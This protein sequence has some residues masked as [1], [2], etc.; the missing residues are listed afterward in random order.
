MIDDFILVEKV[1]DSFCEGDET[2]GRQKVEE[3]RAQY[4]TVSRFA[5][6]CRQSSCEQFEGPILGSAS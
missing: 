6:A 4:D 2:Q 5:T 3:V 1:E